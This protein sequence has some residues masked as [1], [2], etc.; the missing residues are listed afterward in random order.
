MA[1]QEQRA[2]LEAQKAELERELQ[3]PTVIRD[4]QRFATCSRAHAQIATA[5]DHFALLE[6]LDRTIAEAE[7]TIAAPEQELR[8]LAQEDLVRA[9]S[10]RTQVAA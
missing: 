8:E 10:E 1:S 2:Q 5:L 3:D 9:T 4:P 6:Q 7:E